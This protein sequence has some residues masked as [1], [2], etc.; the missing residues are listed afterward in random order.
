MAKMTCEQKHNNTLPTARS[1]SQA[2]ADEITQRHSHVVFHL[3][4]E[5]VNAM[6]LDTSE[7]KELERDR[8]G[9][10]ATQFN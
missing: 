6:K 9:Q 1:A 3:N 5:R 4:L 10:E 8:L 2:N 7:I